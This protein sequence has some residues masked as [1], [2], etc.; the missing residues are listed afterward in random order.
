[1]DTLFVVNMIGL[2]GIC[3]YFALMRRANQ[4]TENRFALLSVAYLSYFLVSSIGSMPDADPE[5]SIEFIFI[6]IVLTWVIG[7]PVARWIY[8]QFFPPKEL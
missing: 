1:M 7:Y 5:T 3:I 2:F 8:R 6:L 4:L